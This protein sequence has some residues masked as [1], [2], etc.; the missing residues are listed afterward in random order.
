VVTE[1]LAGA[2]LMVVILFFF[3]KDGALPGLAQL[4]AVNGNRAGEEEAFKFVEALGGLL[5][6]LT[7]LA[8]DREIDHGADA[9]E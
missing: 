8:A 7:P 9:R 5:H 4:L 2:S 3:L 6:Q 1:F